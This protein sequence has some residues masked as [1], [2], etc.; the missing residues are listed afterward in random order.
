MLWLDY[1]FI[2]GLRGCLVGLDESEKYLRIDPCHAETDGVF[3]MTDL[4]A[5]RGY[6]EIRFWDL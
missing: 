2:K 5:F 1:D 6:A 4:A 3:M